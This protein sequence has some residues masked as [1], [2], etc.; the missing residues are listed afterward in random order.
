MNTKE[1]TLFMWLAYAGAIPFVLCAGLM[2]IGYINLPLLGEL[3]PIINT[4]S[5]VIIAFMAGIYWG[6][7]LNG[8]SHSNLYLLIISNVLAITSW[9]AYL[10]IAM[11]VILLFYS[12]IFVLLLV[13]DFR[14]LSQ[15]IITQRYF[16]TR[17][18]V[19]MIVIASLTIGYA[20]FK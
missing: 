1:N 15:G 19:T 9:L 2:A 13:I 4:Y 18:I 7:Y 12:F 5:L 8:Q 3:A 6:L 17:S 20:A 14:L 10:Y 16:K 11:P